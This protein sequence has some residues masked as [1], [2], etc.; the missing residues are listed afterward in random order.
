MEHTFEYYEYD[1][2]QY[3]SDMDELIDERS[4]VGTPPA[5][6]LDTLPPPP[7]PVICFNATGMRCNC[8]REVRCNALIHAPKQTARCRGVAPMCGC[9]IG[10]IAHVR[11][12]RIPARV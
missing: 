5:R 3:F 9:A 6:I 11:L 7:P 10:R 2:L 12:L 8:C 4:P 1:H